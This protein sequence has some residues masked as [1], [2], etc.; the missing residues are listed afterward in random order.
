MRTLRIPPL[1][2][3][4]RLLFTRIDSADHR[5]RRLLGIA[6]GLV[7]SLGNR[8][9]GVAVSFLSVPLTIGYLGTERYGIWITLGS[10]L[11]WVQLSDFGLG[12]GLTNAVTTAAG[13]DRPDLVRTHLSNA[14]L[15][16]SAIAAAVGA[17]IAAAWPFIDW[18]ALFG[19][20]GP[21]AQAETGPAVA[22]AIAIFLLQFPLSVAG[23]VYLAYQESR[24]GNYWGGAGNILS[25]LALLI[26]T[27]TEGGLVWLVI[28]VSGTALLVNAASTAWLF[29]HHRP[30]LRPSLRAVDV[31]YMRSLSQASGQF[32]L[33]QIMA[34]VTFSSDNFVISHFL[35]ANSVP[36]YSLTYGL[37]NYTVLPQ[38]IAFSYL[39]NAYNEAM[40]R[41]D[42]AWVW[43]TF[44]LHLYG[45]LA[46]TATAALALCTIAKPFIAWWAGPAVVPS[47]ALVLW[48]ASWS[49]VNAFTNPIACLLA[50][51][52]RLRYQIV[53]SAAATVCNIVLSLTL[54]QHWGSVGVIAATVISYIVFVCAPSYIDVRHGLAKLQTAP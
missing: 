50:A 44:H 8:L 17:V 15:L 20:S 11:A 10:L 22:A 39:W 1:A 2:N 12:L 42:I 21:L 41:R 5:R 35:G 47:S 40:A 45:G 6:Q 31:T 54:V 26:V 28:A 14:T 19:I 43:R 37:F 33:I 48:I 24:I 34:L 3:I 18:N 52:A 27:H 7:T 25:L 46:F 9:I 53:Y 23:K 4:P 16:L 51:A 49:I 38:A 29:L 30:A 13:Q 36:E 32:F